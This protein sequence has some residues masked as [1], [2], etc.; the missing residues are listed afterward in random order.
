M[1][2]S[3]VIQAL[4]AL[5]QHNRLQVFRALVALGPQGARPGQLG[6]QVG[7]PNA[8]LSFHLKTLMAAGLIT[9]ERA[10]RELI[11]RVEFQQMNG[12]L[13]YLTENCCQGGPACLD[14][15]ALQALHR[16]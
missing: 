5:A 9:Q 13:A 11:Y 16:C 15:V 4:S 10:G 8:T 6:E 14:A 12:L 3:D 1:K 7:L 2:E